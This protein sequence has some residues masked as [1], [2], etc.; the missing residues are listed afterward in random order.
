MTHFSLSKLNS[1]SHIADFCMSSVNVFSPEKLVTN[2]GLYQGVLIDTFDIKETCDD[3][4]GLERRQFGVSPDVEML[5]RCLDYSG[6]VMLPCPRCKQQQPCDFKLY[7]V[8]NKYMDKTDVATNAPS[9]E[10][11]CG[12]DILSRTLEPKGFLFNI[13]KW[14]DECINACLEGIPQQLGLMRLEFSCTLNEEHKGFADFVIY[15]AVDEDAQLSDE[16]FYLHFCLV[17]EKVGQYPSMADIQ[18]FDIEKYH[19]VM[20][21]EQFHDFKMAIGLYASGVGCGSFVYLRR[22][23]EQLV[24]ETAVDASEKEGWLQ[25]EFQKRRFNEKIDY[26]ESFGTKIIPDSLASVKDKIYG[27]LSQG[28]HASSDEECIALFP[29]MKLIIEEL[30]D[31]KLEQKEKEER[32]RQAKIALEKLQ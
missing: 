2:M 17:M 26:V 24:S 31:H 4:N 32:L 3:Y 6:R 28:V 29:V 22:I 7:S 10:Y 25:E 15:K 23:L 11:H 21:K 30:L 16:D 5:H 12:N 9:P 13:D 27:A 19:K 18:L 1:F 20:N 14:W 8:L